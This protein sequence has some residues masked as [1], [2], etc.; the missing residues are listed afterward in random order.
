MLGLLTRRCAGRLRLAPGHLD[1]QWAP[2]RIEHSDDLF[3]PDGRLSPLQLGQESDSHPCC[4]SQL[5]LT[6]ALCPPG[7]PYD[8]SDFRRRH[9]VSPFPGRENQRRRA[10]DTELS[11]NQNGIPERERWLR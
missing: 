9:F 2:E 10:G 4:S 3:Q 6:E 11:I 1:A 5:I 8:A 7:S